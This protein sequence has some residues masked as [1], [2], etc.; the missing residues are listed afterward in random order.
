M[1]VPTLHL[2]EQAVASQAP[3]SGS[4]PIGDALLPRLDRART[5][6]EVEQVIHGAGHALAW[7]GDALVAGPEHE[8]HLRDS[9][10]RAVPQLLALQD[11]LER[12]LEAEIGKVAA[13]KAIVAHEILRR[14]LSVCAQAP[15]SGDGDLSNLSDPSAR[16]GVAQPSLESMRWIAVRLALLVLALEH[17]RGQGSALLAPL[18]DRAFDTSQTFRRAAQSIGL[19]LTPW[20]DAPPATRWK[21]IMEAA[22]GF[23][24]ALDDDQRRAVGEAWDERVELPPRWQPPSS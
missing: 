12:L 18:A 22:S 23:W 4:H 8:P 10:A 2:V 1:D 7:L 24:G 14:F 13:R 21:R 20:L 15:R 17:L 3:A 9:M 11:G 6:E 5:L 19:D 16:S